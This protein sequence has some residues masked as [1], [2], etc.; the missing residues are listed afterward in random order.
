M[1]DVLWRCRL[2]TKLRSISVMYPDSTISVLHNAHNANVVQ[3]IQIRQYLS[4]HINRD[5]RRVR[6][7]DSDGSQYLGSKCLHIKNYFKM[8]FIQLTKIKWKA[9]V[10]FS[11]FS[12]QMTCNNKTLS[13]SLADQNHLNDSHAHYNKNYKMLMITPPPFTRKSRGERAAVKTVIDENL[14]LP[15]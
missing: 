5:A 12:L 14:E 13:S 8:L 11:D 6:C 1:Y 3:L 7:T 9:A 10:C 4:V 15:I 2:Y